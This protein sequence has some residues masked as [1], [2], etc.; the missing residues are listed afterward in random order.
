MEYK[1]II[2]LLDNTQNKPFEFRT[3]NSVEIYHESLGT[4][5]AS[6]HIKF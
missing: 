5:K 1:T 2:N 3:R 6:N 4:Y